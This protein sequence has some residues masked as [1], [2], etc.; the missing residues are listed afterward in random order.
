M[1]YRIVI[2]VLMLCERQHDAAPHIATIHRIDTLIIFGF[3]FACLPDKCNQSKY[4][5]KKDN[6]KSNVR[7]H[8]VSVFIFIIR[9]YPRRLSALMAKEENTNKKNAS[10][11]L[12]NNNVMAEN[13]LKFQIHHDFGWREVHVRIVLEMRLNAVGYILN[14]HIGCCRHS[15]VSQCVYMIYGTH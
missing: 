13:N 12:T 4:I 10:T 3:S 14:N 9:F 7:R 8:I 6:N 1:N 5:P 11:H 15:P 2:L